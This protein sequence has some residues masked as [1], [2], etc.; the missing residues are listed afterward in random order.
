MFS[1]NYFP[2][3]QEEILVNFYDTVSKYVEY[4]TMDKK[5]KNV[6]EM[7]YIREKRRYYEKKIKDE[8]N[9]VLDIKLLKK[10]LVDFKYILTAKEEFMIYN[11]YFFLEKNDKDMLLNFIDVMYFWG[12]DYDDEIKKINKLIAEKKYQTASDICMNIK[13]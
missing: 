6:H 4:D 9:E 7:E 10:I 3:K 12:T 13:Y 1:I 5:D 8:I 2:Q 11:R